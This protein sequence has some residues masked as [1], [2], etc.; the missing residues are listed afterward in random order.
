MLRRISDRKEAPK[1]QVL[2]TFTILL[3]DVRY[4]PG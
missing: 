3:I 2:L 1:W 4:L